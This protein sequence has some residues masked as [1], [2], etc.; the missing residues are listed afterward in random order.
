MCPAEYGPESFV[1]NDV[2]AHD[3]LDFW[4]LSWLA[5]N[6]NYLVIPGSILTGTQGN[7]LSGGNIHLIEQISDLYA[8]YKTGGMTKS[9]YDY[10]RR[11]LLTNSKIIWD[12]SSAFYSAI[13]PPMKPYALLAEGEFPPLKIL[14]VTLTT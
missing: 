8:Q 13:R 12:P 2:P 5:E 3:E 1:L 9:Q 11:V 10:R 7:L 6:S 14:S 4:M